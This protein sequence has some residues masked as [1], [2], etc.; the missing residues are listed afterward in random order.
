M[1]FRWRGSEERVRADD[2]H[3]LPLPVRSGGSDYT[4]ST[5]KNTNNDNNHKCKGHA[6][7]S[8]GVSTLSI[9]RAG[10]SVQSLRTRRVHRTRNINYKSL[11]LP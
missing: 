1:G 6:L 4:A 2:V 3:P 8:G 9:A 5:L 10:G 11:P 7:R